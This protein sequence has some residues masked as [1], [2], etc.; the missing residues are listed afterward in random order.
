MNSKKYALTFTRPGVSA[1]KRIALAYA[2][3]RLGLDL[4]VR[5]DLDELGADLL[6]DGSVTNLLPLEAAVLP[7]QFNHADRQCAS[8]A[9]QIF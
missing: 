8:H 7:S 2:L 6:G 1:N 4:P 5:A 3:P 9:L